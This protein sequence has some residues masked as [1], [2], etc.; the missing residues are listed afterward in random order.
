MGNVFT[1]DFQASTQSRGNE[2]DSVSADLYAEGTYIHEASFKPEI[3]W[4]F[5]SCI[6]LWITCY[7]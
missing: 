1:G 6:Y 7:A 5:V 4:I 2:M 3:T